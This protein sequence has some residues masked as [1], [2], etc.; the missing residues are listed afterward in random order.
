MPERVFSFGQ[1][2]PGLALKKG[3][4]DKKGWWLVHGGESPPFW[5]ISGRHENLPVHSLT[6]RGANTACIH[7]L[8]VFSYI[9]FTKEL[10]FKNL[11]Q[12][13]ESIK[14]YYFKTRGGEVS[15]K[16][17]IDD[18][19]TFQLMSLPIL[20]LCKTSVKIQAG[21]D[22]FT[23]RLS[24]HWRNWE[25][26]FNI[27]DF[28]KCNVCLSKQ[29]FIKLVS[30]QIPWLDTSAALQLPFSFLSVRGKPGREEMPKYISHLPNNTVVHQT[31][32]E[33]LF[34]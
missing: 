5:R 21:L 6:R 4:E 17:F 25:L 23:A 15:G 1:I 29:W 28:P 2:I 9:T 33:Y 18:L 11:N 26:F 8:W 3:G 31:L 13:A 24:P 16:D 10:I 27:S 32:P 34:N 22:S 14:W 12:S 30:V 20:F 7:Q 19:I